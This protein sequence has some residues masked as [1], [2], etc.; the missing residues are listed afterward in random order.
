MFQK[1]SVPINR[2]IYQMHHNFQVRSQSLVSVTM[3]KVNNCTIFTPNN[4]TQLLPSLL[5]CLINH[6]NIQIYYI[7]CSSYWHLKCSI[8][9]CN[10]QSE[11]IFLSW[12]PDEK[13]I[14][15]IVCQTCYLFLTNSSLSY[16]IS[17]YFSDNT[18]ILIFLNKLPYWFLFTD[19]KL[20]F[21]NQI[22]TTI[23]IKLT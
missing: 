10:S 20:T 2:N 3:L 13:L 1:M 5:H 11:I 16:T 6:C 14:L 17:I 4:E 12:L 9:S 21:E 23:N 15:D 19:S 8:S 22:R 18:R 7:L